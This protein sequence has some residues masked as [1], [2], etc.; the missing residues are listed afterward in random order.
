MLPGFLLVLIQT[1]LA[2]RKSPY[3]RVNR[4]GKHPDSGYSGSIKLTTTIPAMAQVAPPG[5]TVNVVSRTQNRWIRNWCLFRAAKKSDVL[6]MDFNLPDVLQVALLFALFGRPR[7]R[8]ITLDL[9]LGKPQGA[10]LALARWSAQYVDCF[11]V[12]F[13]SS[14]VFQRLLAAPARKFVYVPFK[15]NGIEMVQRC[16]SDEKGYIFCGGRSRRDFRTLFEAVCDLQI[17]V[18]V[19]TS[20]EAEMRPHGSSLEGLAVPRNVEIIRRDSDQQFFIDSMSGATLVVLPLVKDSQTQAGIGVYIQA[21][22][23]QKCVVISAGLGVSDVL[24]DEVVIVEP[25]D[26]A[27]LRAEIERLWNDRALRSEYACRAARYAGSLGGPR[28]FCSRIW[29]LLDVRT[30]PLSPGR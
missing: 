10:S 22:A 15:I 18:K 4:D 21:M 29:E 11:L 9:F 1:S 6:L 28:E 16:R 7:C 13:K 17:P 23:L 2:S 5:A 20:S 30:A 19:V 14:E 8:L 24:T 3:R 26:A 27:Q 12:Y 25:G